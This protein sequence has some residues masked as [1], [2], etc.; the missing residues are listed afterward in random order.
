MAHGRFISRSICTSVQMDELISSQGYEAG[1]LITWLIPHL[2]VAGRV[3]GHPRTI[4]SLVYP[5]REDITAQRVE[6]MLQKAHSL[7]L[8]IRY[9]VDDKSYIV[10]PEF[11][12][13]QVGLRLNRERASV[14]PDS[15]GI[16]SGTTP[17]LLRSNSGAT[18]AD[19]RPREVKISKDKAKSNSKPSSSKEL[20]SVVSPPRKTRTVM[21]QQPD[22]EVVRIVT[23]GGVQEVFAHYRTYHPKAHPKPTSKSKEWILI[24]ARLNEGHPVDNLCLAIDGCHRSSWHQGLNKDNRKFDGLELIMRTGSKVQQFI[25]LYERNPL[26][27]FDE[28]TKRSLYGIKKWMDIQ[29]TEEEEK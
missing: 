24:K 3:N 14:I 7:G 19:G 29:E 20:D 11:K 21:S 9:E 13:H 23:S 1:L 4:K 2:D 16:Y 26:E 27:G 10:F 12:K 18:P 25:E 15:Y 17:A 22:K 6:E 5:M 28:K 8:I